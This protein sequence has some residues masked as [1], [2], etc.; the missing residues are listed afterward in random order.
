VTPILAGLV[1]EYRLRQ[2]V[3]CDGERKFVETFMKADDLAVHF[4]GFVRLRDSRTD[5]EYLGVWGRRNASMFRRLLRERG[6]VFSII[7]RE[8]PNRRIKHTSTFPASYYAR[9][10]AEKA[11]RKAKR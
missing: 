8:Q 11:K 6:A 1:Y 2:T 5:R 10:M 4:G 7:R 3:Y 9:R